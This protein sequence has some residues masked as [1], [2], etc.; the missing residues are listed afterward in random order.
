MMVMSI[1][2]AISAAVAA[3]ITVN[4]DNDGSSNNCYSGSYSIDARDIVDYNNR[5]HHGSS[6]RSNFSIMTF[7]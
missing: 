1:A 7:I 5:N 3:L 6:N 4:S 2:T